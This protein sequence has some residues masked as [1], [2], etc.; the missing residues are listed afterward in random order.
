MVLLVWFFG[1][2]LREVHRWQ[3]PRTIAESGWMKT[4]MHQF[5]GLD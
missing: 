1:Q 4:G 5:K 3:W 2:A